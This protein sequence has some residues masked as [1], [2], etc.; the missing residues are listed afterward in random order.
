MM[1]LPELTVLRPASVAEAV[2]ALRDNPG[3]RLL[4]GGTDIVPNLKYGMYDTQRL[5]ALRG[6]SR[7]LR[8]VREQDGQFLLG[9]LCTI[10]E[11]SESPVVR[12]RLPALADA[13]RQIAGPQLRRM[14]TLGGNL[15]L[16]TRC[17]YVNQ[18]YFWRSALGFCL[19]K[20]GTACHVVAGGKRCVAA[21]SNDTAPVLLAFEARVRLVSPR[22]ER[23]VP[24]RDFYLADGT[25]NTVLQPDELLVEVQVPARAA[26]MRQAFAKLRTR[27]AIDFP[28]LNLAVAMELAGNAL[29]SVSLAVSALAARPALIKGLEDLTGKPADARLAEELGRRA[30][31]QCKP[32]TNIGVDPEWRR[33]VLPVLVRRAVLRALESP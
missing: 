5:V 13:C 2:Q 4:A 20:D 18:T 23:V 28:A 1:T 22:G 9:A 17:V 30:H 6:L 26:S 19:K 3:A 21:A 8:Y 10:E 7:E 12:E 25:H 31:K 33:D 29:R 24:L 27:A 11:L 32:L 16:D 15:C 14:G